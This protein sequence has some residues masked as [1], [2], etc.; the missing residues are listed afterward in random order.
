MFRDGLIKYE[1]VFPGFQ[2]HGRLFG[3]FG[4][5]FA[6][7]LRCQV[8]RVRDDEV[9]LPLRQALP[10]GE[11]VTLHR[12]CGAGRL[13]APVESRLFKR[14][15]IQHVFGAAAPSFQGQT[16]IFLEIDVGFRALFHAD[17]LRRRAE[18]LDAKAQTAGTGAEVQRPGRFH[19]RQHLGSRLS[20]HLGIS[21]GTEHARPHGQF[22]VEERPA[23]A[24]VLQRLPGRTAN[25]QFF[26][27]FRF[28]GVQW[29]V[30]KADVP[31][32]RQ[33]EQ[34]PGV[35]ICVR[36]ARR[37]QP[38][39]HFFDRCP[40]QHRFAHHLPSSGS[41]GSTGVTAAMA[42]SIML[43]SGSKTVS[44][45]TQRPGWRMMRVAMLSERPHHL[46][47]S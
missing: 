16:G 23:A 26:E 30:R 15:G 44:R 32:C 21:T 37:R 34:L 8:G 17:D 31:A 4:L 38:R 39:F 22:K 33:P 45:C 19:A 5:Q 18:P 29:T 3:H 43:S 2:C 14:R 6:H 46:S 12:L 40:G 47:S 24:E 25:G 20:H 41:S 42:T 11:E 10:V 28:G 9:E 35:E 36:T 1:T 7:L 13:H 27:L